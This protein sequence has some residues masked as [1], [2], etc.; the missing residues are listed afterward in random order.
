MDLAEFIAAR[1]DEKEAEAPKIHDVT[2]CDSIETSLDNC[3]CGYP[4]RV[5]REA[6]AWRKILAAHAPYEM[7]GDLY[8]SSCGDVPQVRYPCET[9]RAVA[10]IWGDHPGYQLVTGRLPHQG[11]GAEL[12]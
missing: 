10:G 7:G 9:A 12:P 5:L 8:C 2:G 3:D 11:A 6:G 1:L 4:A